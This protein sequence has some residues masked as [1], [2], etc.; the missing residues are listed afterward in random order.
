[1]KKIVVIALLIGF[2]LQAADLFAQGTDQDKVDALMNRWIRSLT[3]ENIEQYASCYWKDATQL[4]YDTKGSSTLFEGIAA[5][6]NKQQQWFENADYASMNLIYPE[7]NR[8]PYGGSSSWVYVYN[9]IGKYR[10]LEAFYIERRA[11]EFRIIDQ[12]L[13]SNVVVP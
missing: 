6:R 4:I 10:Y 7:P 2:S 12:I 1:M 11:E 8:F 9:N 3:T 13:V 5:I